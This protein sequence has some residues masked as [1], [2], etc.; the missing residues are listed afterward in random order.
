MRTS[1]PEPDKPNKAGQTTGFFHALKE[2]LTYTI[3]MNV[4]EFLKQ[5]KNDKTDI[6][7]KYPIRKIK[8]Y[9]SYVMLYLDDEKIQVSD[10]AYFKYKIKGL[11]GLDDELYD[12][13][14][15]EERVFKAYRGALR[16]ISAKDQ[17]VKQID[18]YLVE[19]GLNKPEK[20]EIIDKLKNC[21]LLDDE[22][23][24]QNRINRL[25]ASLTSNKQIRRKLKDEGISD[26]LI[27]RHL[28]KDED[29]EYL[30]AKALAE[31]YERSIRNK[32]L[33]MKKQAQLNRL[34]GQGYSYD[35][36]NRVI[37][38]LSLESENEVELLRKEYLK[39]LKR[40]ERKYDSYELKDHIVS[41]LLAKGFGYEDIKEVMEEENGQTG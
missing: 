10:E 20:E 24:T 13:L 14:K 19:K 29:E 22:K 1:K 36:C 41:Y 8:A 16:K 17:T 21:G 5:N 18:R 3:G 4:E 31:K 37:D 27:Q 35:I 32:T 25:S 11:K 7:I 33:K 12:M 30:K 9:E 23:Y 15:N 2:S 28:K 6:E 26:E 38:A 40:Y 34:S 39:A